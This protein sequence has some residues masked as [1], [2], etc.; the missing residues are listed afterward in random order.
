MDFP[1]VS[2][3]STYAK[4]IISEY[5]LHVKDK[6]IVCKNMG[7]IA[8]GQVRS[9]ELTP[10]TVFKLITKHNAMCPEIFM[11]RYSVQDGR[12]CQWTFQWVR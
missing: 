1:V 3:A 8:G 6:G 2:T 11:E 5:Y 9:N 4:T 7:G 12:W 10:S